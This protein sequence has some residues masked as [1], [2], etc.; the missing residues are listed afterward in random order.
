MVTLG[1]IDSGSHPRRRAALAAHA[2]REAL[3][4]AGLLELFPEC[5][6]DVA[7]GRAVV[8]L[9]AIDAAAALVLAERLRPPRRRR[10]ARSANAVTN[11]SA[12]ADVRQQ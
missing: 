2:L 11:D 7:D 10:T 4:D 9:G 6:A 1:S 8:Q 12:S 3:A 5:T